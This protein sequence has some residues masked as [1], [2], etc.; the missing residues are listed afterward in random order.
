MSGERLGTGDRSQVARTTVTSKPR[1]T[2]WRHRSVAGA[3]VR[4]VIVAMIDAIVSPASAGTQMQPCRR[5]AA[6]YWKRL[7]Q[8]RQPTYCFGARAG[9]MRV[10]ARGPQREP[11]DTIQSAASRQGPSGAFRRVG[12]PRRHRPLPGASTETV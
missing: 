11:Y 5:A 2:E 4:Q 12:R 8:S 9:V 10:H 1:E 3:L 6:R 7:T